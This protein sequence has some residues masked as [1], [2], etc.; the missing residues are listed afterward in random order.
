[1]APTISVQPVGDTVHEH[2][3]VT[4]EVTAS[5]SGSGTLS[6]QWIRNTANSYSGGYAINGATSSTFVVPTSYAHNDYYYVMVTNTDNSVPGTKTASTRS[7]FAHV[8]VLDVT[9]PSVSISS[10]QSSPTNDSP[11]NVT[12]TFSEAVTGFTSADISVTNGTADNLSTLDNRIYTADITPSGDGEV[13]VG[14]AADVAF[15]GAA[16]GNTA[17]TELSIDYDTTAPT[18]GINSVQ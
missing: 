15:D 5:A 18:V 10:A 13:K 11:I 4:L 8:I 16:N 6:Y 12:F 3:V 17:A 14:V 9:P 2:D 7:D 1:P